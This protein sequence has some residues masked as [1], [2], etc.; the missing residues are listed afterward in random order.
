MRQ[1]HEEPEPE[2]ALVADLLDIVFKAVKPLGIYGSELDVWIT[3]DDIVVVNHDATF[4]TDG[5]G[6]DFI[7][8]NQPELAKELTDKVFI[9]K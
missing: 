8:T 3:R 9:E 5:W 6:V 1:I 7:T 2:P 4:P